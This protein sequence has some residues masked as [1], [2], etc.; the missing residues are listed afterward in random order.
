MAKGNQSLLQGPAL[1]TLPHLLLSRLPE[2]CRAVG[3]SIT[4]SSKAASLSPDNFYS[5]NMARRREKLLSVPGHRDDERA[6][7]S[8]PVQR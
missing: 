2:L 3:L 7:P 8:L 4:H 1:L 5:C 6:K